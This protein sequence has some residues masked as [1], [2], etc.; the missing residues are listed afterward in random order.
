MRQGRR[1]SRRIVMVTTDRN[2]LHH[3]ILDGRYDGSSQAQRTVEGLRSKT[4]ELLEYGYWGY[5]SD[6]HHEPAGQ[7]ILATR[8]VTFSVTPHLVRLP[9]LPSAVALHCHLQTV[10]SMTDCRSHDGPSC[11][12][13]MK[14]REVAP[15]P[16]F[17]EFMCF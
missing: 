9:H 15:V 14:I 4:L 8:S 7:T 6:L 2:G 3:P 13:V 12:F 16:I 11:R 10:T 17:Q 5:F 1:T